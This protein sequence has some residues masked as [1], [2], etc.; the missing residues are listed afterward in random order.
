MKAL[1]ATTERLAMIRERLE[2]GKKADAHDWAV[3]E[4][5]ARAQR[6]MIDRGLEE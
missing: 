1:D 6:E 5:I 4:F 2:H 3:I